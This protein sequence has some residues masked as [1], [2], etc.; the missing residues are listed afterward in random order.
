MTVLHHRYQKRDE[1]QMVIVA[2]KDHRTIQTCT[3][4]CCAIHTQSQGA[5]GAR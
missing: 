3:L 4:I 1:C 5:S 2:G